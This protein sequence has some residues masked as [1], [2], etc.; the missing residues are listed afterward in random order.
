[1]KRLIKKEEKKERDLQGQK[2]KVKKE[3]DIGGERIVK[4]VDVLADR[5]LAGVDG[6]KLDRINL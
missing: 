3:G 6:E 2:M 5:E 1:M 4:Q